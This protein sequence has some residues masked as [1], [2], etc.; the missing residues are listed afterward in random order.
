MSSSNAS[1]SSDSTEAIN[2]PHCGA[3]V[4]YERGATS[5]TCHYCGQTIT[6][7]HAAHT[8]T[9]ESAQSTVYTVMDVTPSLVT[10][11]QSRKGSIGCIVLVAGFV[12]FMI[13]VTVVLPIALTNQALSSIPDMPSALQ[14]MATTAANIKS[15][16]TR[17][18]PTAAPSPTPTPAFAKIALQFGEKGMGPG[19]FTNAH[20]GGVDGEG[21]IYVGEYIGGRGQGVDAKGKFIDQFFVGDKKTDLEGFVV[22]RNGVVYVAD[23]TDITRYDGKTGKALGK[24]KYSGGP[25]FGELALAP[26]GSLYAM[27]YERRSGIFTST[28]GA[29]ED[30]VHFDKNGK[31]LKVLP[32]VLSSMTDNV[33]LANQLA[34]DGRGNVY[35]APEFEGTLFKFDPNGKFITRI[36]GSGDG[37]SQFSSLGPIAVDGQGRIYVDDSSNLKILKPDG[38]QLNSIDVPGAPRS[39][40]FDDA[41]A[42]WVTTDDGI[43]K[44][45]MQQK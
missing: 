41:G 42:L 19:Q 6:I 14:D 25:G 30:L 40:V 1:P 37:P 15:K 5:V 26:D 4:N 27:W 45:Q 36:G 13:L 34:V 10:A 8:T 3:V 17:R 11:T 43:V 44:Y 38:S 32:G 2:C 28:E 23:G 18:A 20:G 7:P 31:V 21:R 29:R 9:D 16:P 39:L 35:L 24:I 33:E 22:D 12:I